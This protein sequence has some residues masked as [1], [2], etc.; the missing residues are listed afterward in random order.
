MRNAARARII[1]FTWIGLIAI[2]STSAMAAN[3]ASFVK[4]DASTVGNWIGHYGADGYNVSQDTTVKTPA[5]A[6]INLSGASNY[7]W[8]ASPSGTAALQRPENPSGR[9]AS[10]WYAPDSFFIDVNLTDGKTHQIALYNLD[11]DWSI[12]SQTINVRDASTNAILDSR[13]LAAGAAFHNGEYLVWNVQGHV[14]YE[15]IRTGAFNAVI[16]GI[17]F[18]APN[19]TPAGSLSIPTYHATLANDGQNLKET[20]LT[21][22]NVSSASFGKIVSVP[23]TGDVYTQP[24][25]QSGVNIPGKGTHDTVFTVT[26]LGVAYAIDAYSGAVLW[27][28][29]LMPPGSTALVGVFTTP[30]ISSLTN[31]MYVMVI[32]G[33]SDNTYTYALFS[34]NLT[35]G[36]PYAPPAVIGQI[37]NTNTYVSGPTTASGK[38]F[39]GNLVSRNLVLN[40][41]NNAVYASFSAGGDKG[42][43][44]GW[45]VGYNSVKNGSGNLS[46]V[47]VWCATPNGNSGGYADGGDGAGGIWMSG[48]GI[49][50]DALGDMYLATG[51]G[52]FEQTLV[53]VP[54]NGRL[55]TNIPNL[56]VPS[57]MDFGDSVIKLRPDS[58]VN[59][60]RGDNPNGWGLHVADY[61][62]PADQSF[63]QGANDLDVGTSS[64]V[65]LSSAA[66]STAHPNLLVMSSKEG[67]IWLIDRNN[68]G[69]FNSLTDSAVQKV[70]GQ[71]LPMFSTPAYYSLS[72][73]SPVLYYI[74]VS[75]GSTGDFAKA[76]AVNNGALSG[77]PVSVG[78]Y[79][80]SKPGSTPQISANGGSNGIVWALDPGANVLLALN[81]GSLAMMFF[82]SGTAANALP[83][84]M[85]IS[86]AFPTP[87]VAAG[88][89]YVGTKGYLTIYGLH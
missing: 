14:K 84:A 67:E 2:P 82:N 29:S 86:G 38:K 53:T 19:G 41:I 88:H 55:S 22:T 76:F 18:D 6:Q 26:N 43:F 72:N 13:T 59:Q 64:P 28:S 71:I 85:P 89:V 31:A 37:S 74:A 46:Q 65:L 81:A 16:S 77:T 15:I 7:V 69:G 35:D 68:M 21:P 5:Y 39:N 8:S 75:W 51:N 49:A 30:V 3:S 73:P 24:V 34:L 62:T 12:R 11:F 42:P 4:V 52:S 33:N 79:R 56:K 1:A 25:F 70:T 83:S 9:I 32:G 36:K 63:R 66:G 27:T 48:G 23:L 60:S 54:Y 87:M 50:V 17:F 61:F 47:A 80:F 45:I 20:I 57:G 44:N 40:P 10:T 78:T 58:D